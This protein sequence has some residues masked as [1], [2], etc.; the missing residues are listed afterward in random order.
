MK[1]LFR[2]DASVSIGSGHIM[3]CLTLAT[4][5]RARGV[6]CH[7]VSRKHDGHL[8]ELVR[9]R[10]FEVTALVA[11]HAAPPDDDGPVHASWLGCTWE[12]D[13]ER[14]RALAVTMKPDWIVLDHYALDERWE[15][16][17]SVA[18][19]RLLVID[20]LADRTHACDLLVDQN[21]GRA[22]AHYSALVP[23]GCSV[24]AGPAYALLRPEFARLRPVSLARRNGAT[25]RHILVNMGGVDQPNATGAVLAALCASDLPP[26]CRIS[27][28][29]GMQAP[30][31]AEVQAFAT[32]MSWATE[33]LVNISDMA[34]RM[35]DSD[36]AIGAAGSTSWER[37][38]LGLPTLMVILAANQESSAA[39]LDDVGAALLLGHVGDIPRRLPAALTDV[40]QPDRLRQISDAAS[41]LVDGHGVERLLHALGM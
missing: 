4:A 1:F 39:A 34:E 28:V 20:D 37:C 35:A 6:S 16:F 9:Q 33:V 10:G 8:I 31:I 7:F 18:G 12:S 22:A 36:M 11:G 17:V 27:V 15:R 21:L 24:L 38:C 5:L 41:A 2:V 29:M 26:D 40:M 23:D 32:R 13:A 25:L 3:R 19:T 30:W 14:T